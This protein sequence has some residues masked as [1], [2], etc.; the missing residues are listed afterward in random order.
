VLDECR[1]AGTHFVLV[2]QDSFASLMGLHDCLVAAEERNLTTRKVVINRDKLL[3]YFSHIILRAGYECLKLIGES[4][5]A[6]PTLPSELA[7]NDAA[8]SAAEVASDLADPMPR[9]ELNSAV[10][11]GAAA[12]LADQL[13]IKTDDP[14]EAEAAAGCCFA[15]TPLSPLLCSEALV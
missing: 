11:T 4:L 1:A 10:A 9:L 15:A 5:I 13:A 7:V 2:D 14:S 8:C 12:P 3:P 6:A